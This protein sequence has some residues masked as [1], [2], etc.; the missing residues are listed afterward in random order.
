MTSRSAATF[1]HRC[2]RSVRL[3][4]RTGF[5]T[6]AASAQHLLAC[7]RIPLGCRA[8]EPPTV[9]ISPSAASI[10]KRNGLAQAPKC[11]AQKG[12]ETDAGSIEGEAARILNSW[13]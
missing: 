2:A 3:S 13:F 6:S 11:A 5:M 1:A 7:A 10:S 9:H 8:C 4:F 12:T